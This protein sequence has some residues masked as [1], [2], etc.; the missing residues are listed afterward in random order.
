MGRWFRLFIPVLTGTWAVL[1]SAPTLALDLPGPVTDKDFR[2]VETAKAELGRLLFYDAEL[3][4]NRNISC[5]TCHHHDEA[6]GDG[7]SLPVGEGGTGIGLARKVGSGPDLIERRVPRHSPTLFNLG[8]H[9]FTVMFHDGRVTVDDYYE[10]GFNTPVDDDLPMGLESVLAAQAMFPVL[11]DV[12]MLG[13]GEENDLARAFKYEREDVWPKIADRLRVI[14]GYLPL[15]SRAFADVAT[16]KDI[17]MV[18]VANALAAFIEFE[19]RADN[20]PFDS[21]LRGDATALSAAQKRGMALFYG[22]AGCASCHSGPFQT[23][24]GFHALAMPQ[25]G[26]I[27][28]GLFN[29]IVRDRGRLN[30]TGRLEDAYR[31]RTPSLRNVAATPPYTHAGAYQTLEGVIRHHLDPVTAFKAYDRSQALLTPHPHLTKTD[32]IIYENSREVDA[33]M[34]ANDLAPSSLSE[35]EIADLVA[36]LHALTDEKSLTGRYGAPESVPSGLPVD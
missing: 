15:F 25:L 13:E 23:D 14:E 21:Y 19:W 7:L 22:D 16:P 1:L 2:P 4:G 8:A 31:F 17:T 33:I 32:F 6:S 26:S 11:S 20:S 29:P 28:T 5:A 30:E 3:S 34:A 10:A 24:H 9:E 12:E 36:F 27:R 35:G 18:H